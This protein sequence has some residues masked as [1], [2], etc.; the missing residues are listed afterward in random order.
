MS[1]PLTKEA[2]DA[3]TS[4]ASKSRPFSANA[5]PE[6]AAY[7]N[8]FQP[9]NPGETEKS[10]ISPKGMGLHPVWGAHAFRVVDDREYLD[11]CRT[12][13]G[14]VVD[15]EYFEKSKEDRK[16]LVEQSNWIAEQLE[17]VGVKAFGD[18]N[19]SIVGLCSGIVQKLPDFRNIVFIPVVAARKRA[20]MLRQL[21]YFLTHHPFCRMWVV[22]TEGR[23]GL[24]GVRECCQGLHRRLSKLNNQSF[25]QSA[26]AQIVFRSTELGSIDRDDEGEPTFH[27]H[28]H[29][30]VYLKKKLPKN[31]WRH[32][33][34]QVR[35]WWKFHFKEAEQ[36]HRARE[37]CKYVVKPQ[38]LH[39]LNALE[40]KL[41]YHEMFKLHLVQPMGVFKSQIKELAEKNQKLIRTKE[42]DNWKLK[43][44]PKW[45][46]NRKN[47]RDPFPYYKKEQPFNWILTTLPPAPILSPVSEPVAVVLNYCGKEVFHKKQARKARI[48]GLDAYNAALSPGV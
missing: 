25:M 19:L 14:Q 36:I 39:K 29:L 21:E 41:L 20:P 40:L 45:I 6:P 43:N 4:K 13:S 28:A 2:P 48:A 16:R 12:N 26:G 31:D 22:T 37:A 23:V 34:V 10:S 38:E 33:L 42:G 3:A 15:L 30:I 5:S 11:L 24:D 18:S 32:L 47:C 17:S 27:I 35:A 7:E 1:I 46:S 8:I 9:V 44:I